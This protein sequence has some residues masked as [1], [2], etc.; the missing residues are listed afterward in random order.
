VMA[1]P[2]SVHQNTTVRSNNLRSNRA[3]VEY[4]SV[5]WENKIRAYL[6]GPVGE[7]IV[8]ADV[9]DPVPLL[10]V[11]VFYFSFCEE[12][13]STQRHVRAEVEGNSCRSL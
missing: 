7:S 9:V 11:Q 13:S 8:E 1:V 5:T 3:R 4:S 12:L 2:T 6:K 10:S